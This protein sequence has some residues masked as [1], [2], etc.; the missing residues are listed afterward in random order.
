MERQWTKK[1]SISKRDG[2]IKIVSKL[3]DDL[4]DQLIRRIGEFVAML[5]DGAKIEVE[6][7]RGWRD[8]TRQPPHD[9]VESVPTDEW[10]LKVLV[11]GGANE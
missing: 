6:L 1:R 4:R 5:P 11:S 9:I 8:V 3:D 2:S 10:T 7:L